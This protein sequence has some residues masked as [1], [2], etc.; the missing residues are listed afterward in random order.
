MLQ[1]IVTPKNYTPVKGAN[2]PDRNHE[3]CVGEA[4]SLVGGGPRMTIT[5]LRSNDRLLAT[6]M[7]GQGEHREMEFASILCVRVVEN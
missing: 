4:V 3:F 2:F 1:S 5:E 7:N 6:W